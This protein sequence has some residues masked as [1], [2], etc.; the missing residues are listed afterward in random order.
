M[1][2]A[3]QT[4]TVAFEP[5]TGAEGARNR[6][7]S[8]WAVYCEVNR[9]N[10]RLACVSQDGVLLNVVNDMNSASIEFVLRGRIEGREVTPASIGLSR[11]N[12]FNQDVET[13]LRGSQRLELDEVLVSVEAGSYKLRVLLPAL[14]LSSVS[15]DIKLLAREDSLGEVDAKR[16]EVVQKWQARSKSSPELSYELRPQGDDTTIIRISR[17]S[18]Y[19]VGAIIPWV[20]VEKYVSG[21][22]VDMGG[23]QKANIHLKIGSNK[24]IVRIDTSQGYLRDQPQN[25]LY[26]KA[27]LHVRAEQHFRTGELRNIRLIEFVPYQ[28]VYDEAAL[29]RFGADGVQAWA[30]VPDAA[31]WVREVRGG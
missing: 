31:A 3:F 23:A 25:W 30:D 28:P 12:E 17:E 9:L 29:N 16:A 21:E 19:R 5:L 15:P 24:R 22:V 4:P 26:H 18:D 7:R 27:L 20:S 11:F 10:A 13:F 8:V 1:D 14:V 6:K 2:H